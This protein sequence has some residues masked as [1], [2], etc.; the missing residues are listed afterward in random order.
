MQIYETI[1]GNIYQDTL[2]TNLWKSTLQKKVAI[3]FFTLF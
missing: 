1:I 2:K 3:F